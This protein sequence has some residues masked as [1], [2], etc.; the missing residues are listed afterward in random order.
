MN[1]RLLVLLPFLCCQVLLSPSF[2]AA[3]TVESPCMTSFLFSSYLF[4]HW[5]IHSRSFT[6]FN[7]FLNYLGNREL[8]RQV[9][10]YITNNINP[11]LTD[12]DI[13]PVLLTYSLILL[14]YLLNI[15]IYYRQRY[16]IIVYFIQIMI[17]I[18][19]MKK[20]KWK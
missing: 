14:Q 18:N 19:I 6:S 20:I 8:S 5:L 9:R 4:H 11:I 2:T 3:E 17:F 7:P 12:Y 1:D 16:Q 15:F 10:H 13:N